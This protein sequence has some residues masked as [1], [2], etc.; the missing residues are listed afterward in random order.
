M[1]AGD[2]ISATDYNNIRKKVVAVMGT[3]K[4]GGASYLYDAT[5]GYG[6]TV[7]SSNVATTA[8]VT[9]TQWDQLR[10]DL[11]NV[12]YHQTGTIPSITSATVGS[13]IT[14]GPTHPNTQYDTLASTAVTNRFSVGTGQYIETLAKASTS[15]TTNW[16]TSVECT[17]TCDFGTADDARYFFNSG[18]EIKIRAS[19]TGGDATQQNTMWSS[20]LSGAGTRSFGGQL[21]NTGFTPM[22]GLNFY[23]LTSTA[24]RYYTTTGSSPYATNRYSLWAYCDVANNSAGTARYLYI[25]V[26]LDDPYVDPPLGTPPASTADVGPEDIVNGTLTVTVD[27]KKADGILQPA[28]STG[29]FTIPRVGSPLI[30]ITAGAWTGS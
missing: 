3:G 16:S 14:Y 30:N 28:P 17:I 25:K 4:D 21:P 24:Q 15:R 29:N 6:Q 18:G 7:L 1:A 5:Y 10:Y 12:L 27:E 20:I 11:Y 8:T 2:L 9:K 26:V 23:R 13:V 19:R 22:D